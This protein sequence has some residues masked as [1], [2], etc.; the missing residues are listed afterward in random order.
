MQLTPLKPCARLGENYSGIVWD[1]ICSRV[2]KR[3]WWIPGKARKCRHVQIQAVHIDGSPIRKIDLFEL[4]RRGGRRYHRICSR[5]GIHWYGRDQRVVQHKVAE[6]GEIGIL[7]MRVVRV[8]VTVSYDRPVHLLQKHDL[9]RKEQ[10]QQTIAENE[11]SCYLDGE[12]ARFK[13]V[14]P[15]CEPRRAPQWNEFVKRNR[16]IANVKRVLCSPRDTFSWNGKRRVQRI[17]HEV[18]TQHRLAHV[19]H[20]D[21]SHDHR[22]L[23]LRPLPLPPPLAPG[24]YLT[25]SKGPANSP[26]RSS[27]SASA[28]V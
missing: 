22:K 11:A 7:V 4:G 18:H 8:I 5:E 1:N 26:L 14:L 24:R 28:P 23:E 20:S 12:R 10:N 27:V 21:I 6:R 16:R 15:V 2:E 3:I 25:R 9:G 13:T 19:K 17:R